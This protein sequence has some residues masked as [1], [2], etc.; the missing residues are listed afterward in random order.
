M[1]RWLVTIRIPNNPK[2]RDPSLKQKLLKDI[3]GIHQWCW[4]MRDEEMA[5]AFKNRGR[6]PSIQEAT[7]ENLLESHPVLRFLLETYQ[8]GKLSI[9]GRDLYLNFKNWAK[10]TGQP[11]ITETK[12]G[13][14]AKK[15]VGWVVSTKT[16]YGVNYEI[17][18]MNDFNLTNHFGFGS[19]D[20]EL[21][22]PPKSTHHRNPTPLESINS[23]RSQEKVKGMKAL[24]LSF[25]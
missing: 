14:E 19:N 16:K 21:N 15:L 23:N 17:K 8:D 4:T 7:I 11:P 12:F 20:E 10:D 5:E 24:P 2:I 22:S 1:G 18:P 9:A 13:L 25:N 6:I 3:A